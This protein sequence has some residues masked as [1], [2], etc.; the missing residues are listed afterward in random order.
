MS[1]VAHHAYSEP[2]VLLPTAACKQPLG[3]SM[4]EAGAEGE[5]QQV[6]AVSRQVVPALHTLQHY[7]DLAKTYAGRAGG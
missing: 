2:Q 3:G 4:C 6:R 7:A 1:T 5:P